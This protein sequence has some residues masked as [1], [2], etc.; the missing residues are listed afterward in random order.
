MK[1]I[2]LSFWQLASAMTIATM[3]IAVAGAM[4]IIASA[5]ENEHGDGGPQIHNGHDHN[6]GNHEGNDNNDDQND[7]DGEGDEVTGSITVCKVLVDSNGTALA[8]DSGSNFSI[9]LSKTQQTS[10]VASFDT[11]LSLD[12]T[13]INE[14]PDGQCQTYS[15][16]KLGTWNYG[17]ESITSS[18]TFETPMYSDQFSQAV[19]SPSDLF[20]YNTDGS[21]N[22]DNADGNITL[23]Q[24]RKDRTLIVYNKEKPT[25]VTVIASKVVCTNPSQLPQWGAGGHGP[26]TATTAQDWVSGEGHGTCSIVP[27]WTFEYGDSTAGDGGDATVGHVAGY[28]AFGPTTGSPA[29]ASVIIPMSA[30]GDGTE[31]HLREQLQA[32]FIPFTFGADHTNSTYPS[33]QFYC[34]SDVLNNDNFDFIRNPVAGQTYQCVAFN[35]P[36]CNATASQTLVSDPSTLMGVAPT[37]PVSP[38]HVA[39]TASIPGATWVWGE[40]PIGDAVN[41]TSETFTRTFNIAGTP[42]GATLDVA[43]DNSYTIS[44]NGHAGAAD[45]GEFN[46]TLTG[47][48]NGIVIPVGD[49]V[50]GANT[51]SFTVTNFAQA[52]GTMATNP[53][54]LLYRLVVNNNECVTPPPPQEC[55]VDTTGVFPDCVPNVPSCSTNQILVDNQC[56]SCGESQ[57]VADN[58]CV[59]NTLTCEDNQILVENECV[60]CGENQHVTD[61]QCVDNGG[62]SDDNNGGS[63]NDVT[64]DAITGGNGPIAGSLGGG[65]GGQVLGAS[66]SAL[67]EG[68]SALLTTYMRLGKK[69]NDPAEVRLLQQFLNDTIH[70][71]LPITGFFGKATDR[72]VRD[73]Q[74]NYPDD[75]LTPW[76]LQDPTGF[77]YR[78]TQRWINLLHCQSLNIPMPT[79]L[80]PYH[81]E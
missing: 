35:A 75:V 8:G 1:T 10:H 34:A 2:R 54:G 33:A 50:S 74:S 60:S 5:N 65:S 25:A 58:Q 17:Q 70:T 20:A 47:Q 79:D 9:T 69:N 30:L 67:P 22:G 21:Q 18:A 51:I 4:P 27:G 28:T 64:P 37:V 63:G 53:A 43:A 73:F 72:A 23:T 6:T 14:S 41:Q 3:V 59:D 40:N 19:N 46:Y 39:W 13:V 44:V 81:G 29:S 78:T 77:V 11:P 36:S 56:V 42:T 49:L 57:H 38:I 68:C 31:F 62:G 24:N 26:I 48:D 61:N 16:L 45:V 71:N 12:S 52:G 80:T 76:G 15:N 32:G 55:P 66:T 7:N